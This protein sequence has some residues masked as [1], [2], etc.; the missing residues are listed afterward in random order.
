MKSKSTKKRPLMA[1]VRGSQPRMA[2]MYFYGKFSQMKIRFIGDRDTGWVVD[3]H[4]PLT[5]DY[6][7]SPLR[8]RWGFDPVTTFFGLY[9]AHRSWQWVDNLSELVREADVINTSD[10]FYFYSGQCA[11]LART[12]N[13][14]LVAVVW[15]TVPYHISTYL[16]PYA[17][18]VSAMLSQTDLFIARSKKAREYLLSIGADETKVRVIYKG[19]DLGLFGR[20]PRLAAS[21]LR[22]LYVGQLVAS[23]GVMELL[24][25]FERVYQDFPDSELWLV[26]RS[27]G[28][29]LRAVI[30]RYCTRLPIVVK[31][32]VAYE[33]L[34]AI[35]HAAHIYC[36][37]SCDWRY[38]GIIPG[39]NDWFPYAVLEA[40]AAGL[41]VVA[42]S[43]GG[44]PEQLGGE[45]FLVPQRTVEP[46]YRA[47][48]TLALAPGLRASLGAANR[49]RVE[50][51][52]EVT[53][54]ARETEAAILDLVL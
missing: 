48:K 28:E 9:H 34:P 29:P 23:K 37:L 5:I 54:Q 30:D 49:K 1:V 14:K 21:P 4:I 25:A 20:A 53:T 6:I 11:H 47:L 24:A 44:I 10:L 16:P 52:F 15:E 51:M 45:N 35:Y 38:W 26:G 13:K 33:Q 8:P 17:G 46:V 2:E 27:N 32:Q 41:P 19:V 22:I 39:G 12:L 42:T 7:H 43:V 40:M 36:H 3:E 18:N 31:E 50:K